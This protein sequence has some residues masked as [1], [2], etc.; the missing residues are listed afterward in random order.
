MKKI[1]SLL[2]CLAILLTATMLFSC[3]G[4]KYDDI[5][6]VETPYAGSTLYVYNWGEYIADGSDDSRDIIKIF[7][8]KYGI[9][10]KYSYFISNEEMYTQIKNGA[11]YDIIIPSDYMINRLIN[12]NLIQK[13]DFSNITNYSNI[14]DKYKNLYFDPNNEYS[15]PYNVGMVGIIYNKEMVDAADVESQSWNLM[16]NSKYKN[17]VV[18]FNNSRDAFGTAQY[19]LGL[20]VNSTSEADWQAAYDKLLEQKNNVQ[21]A[22]LMDEIYNKMEN[23]NSAIAAYYAGDCL[24]M[25][26]ENEN[27]DFFYPAE[28]TNIFVD[29]MCI[30]STAKNKGAAELFINFMLE[31]DIAVENANYICY[32]SPNKTV[33]DNE[34]YDYRVGTKEY[35]IL[36]TLPESYQND[37]SRM[38]YFHDLSTEAPEMQNLLTKLW[39]QLGIEE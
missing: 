18:N 11:S 7:E 13:I 34:N 32:A 12:E 23:E 10:V 14:D 22:Y 21:P 20:S 16:W 5:E 26:Q 39:T 38:Q 33:W 36:Y 37:S 28:G 27:L 29:S 1:V 31:T 15:V 8:K 9:T 24:Q 30:P 19:L 6:Y 25:M 2:L 4:D 17:N 3:G 35:D